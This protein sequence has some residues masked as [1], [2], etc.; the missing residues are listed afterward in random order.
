MSRFLSL[1]AVLLLLVGGLPVHAQEADTS[2]TD[3]SATDTSTV[4]TPTPDTSVT[5]T[6]VADTTAAEPMAADTTQAEAVPADT[7]QADSLAAD[8]AVVAETVDL[9][10]QELARE[11]AESWLTMID[12][13]EFG[14]SWDAATPSF[15]DGR[16]REQ[17]ISQATQAREQLQALQSR[18]LRSTQ[19]RDSTARLPGGPVAVLQYYSKFNGGTT[20]EAVITTRP[21][22]IWRVAGYRV[23][24]APDSVTAP[25]SVAVPDSTQAPSD[26]TEAATS[27]E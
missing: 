21:D 24:P 11:A 5:D 10:P 16:T 22:S 8:S 26:T 18:Q 19:Y 12:S 1:A 15:Q 2:A 13:S 7:V 27:P 20:L 14:R 25:D 3:T 6:S 17:W 23:V 4:E 9:S